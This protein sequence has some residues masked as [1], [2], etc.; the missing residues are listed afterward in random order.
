MKKR[1]YTA[2]LTLL[3]VLS[4]S[5]IAAAQDETAPE[6]TSQ[7]Q[8]AVSPVLETSRAMLRQMMGINPE[9]KEAPMSAVAL[10]IYPGSLMV[11]HKYHG[12]NFDDLDQTL[13]FAT[14]LTESS[15]EQVLQFYREKLPSY[16]AIRYE[17]AIVL[18]QEKVEHGH[19]PMDYLNIPNV[20]IDSVTL[21]NGQTGTLI[22][23]MYPRLAK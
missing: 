9:I 12:I 19:Y 16:T 21:S 17:T 18:V 7:K 23:V 1:I 8:T 5:G 11:V 3:G 2:S 10:P 22:A 15:V 6:P 4:L 20:S 13:P 14:F